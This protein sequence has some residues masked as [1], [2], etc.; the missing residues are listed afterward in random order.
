VVRFKSTWHRAVFLI[1]FSFSLSFPNPALA[2]TLGCRSILKRI[3]SLIVKDSL[4]LG[5]VALGL[6]SGTDSVGHQLGTTHLGYQIFLDYPVILNYL[7]TEE[8]KILEAPNKD[9]ERIVTILNR[10]LSQKYSPGFEYFPFLKPIMASN[11][12]SDH[13]PHTN[14]CRHKAIILKGILNHLGTEA[15]L[16]TGSIGG[17][18]DSPEEHVWVYVPSINKFADP[19]NDILLPTEDYNRFNQ[20]NLHMNVGLFPKQAGLFGR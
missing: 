14:V 13:P 4:I 10:Y 6:N 11:F 20:A 1:F 16:I 2:Q 17:D 7:T 19:M 8:Q 5:A 15:K 12:F 9:V 3:G 18:N